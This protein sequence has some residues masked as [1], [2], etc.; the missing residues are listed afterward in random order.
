[1]RFDIVLVNEHDELMMM[2]MMLHYGIVCQLLQYC[3]VVYS[4]KKSIE[5]INFNYALLGK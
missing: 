5:G 3:H 4:F 1:M 2:M